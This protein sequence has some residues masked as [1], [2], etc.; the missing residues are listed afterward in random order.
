M[1]LVI[2][3]S[4]CLALGTISAISD[5]FQVGIQLWPEFIDE[6]LHSIYL[7]F[8]QQVSDERPPQ[9][10]PGFEEGPTSDFDE[11]S[12]VVVAAPAGAFGNV[13]SNR[14]RRPDKLPSNRVFRK[15]IPA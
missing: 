7:F 14:I 8:D 6:V 2:R 11:T 13:G 10:V 4:F 5:G 3:Q 9:P 15:W 1:S 12:I